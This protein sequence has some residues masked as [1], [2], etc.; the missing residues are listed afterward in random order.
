MLLIIDH[1]PV[2]AQVLM[3]LASGFLF[4]YLAV[5]WDQ[6]WLKA[7]PLWFLNLTAKYITPQKSYWFIALAI[8]GFNAA[9][10]FIYLLSGLI[11]FLP[12]LVAFFIGLNV[13]VLM[14]EPPKEVVGWGKS[15]I[16]LS[17]TRAALADFLV[18]TG[19]IFFCELFVLSFALAFG[20][21]AGVELG[22]AFTLGAIKQVLLPRIAVYFKCGLPLLFI[23]A[24]FEAKLI[25]K[26]TH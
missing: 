15:N 3:L 4:A 14:F 10:I 5:R 22:G 17:A 13:G 1:L 11:A 12:Y 25:K 7:F 19:V 9:A 20:V 24:L 16:T 26:S 6:A 23:S 18:S 2:M 21:S 8:F